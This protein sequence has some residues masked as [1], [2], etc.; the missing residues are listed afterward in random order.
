MVEALAVAI[1]R[2]AAGLVAAAEQ[3]RWEAASAATAGTGAAASAATAP[4]TWGDRAVQM[5][6]ELL[7]GALQQPLEGEGGS[8]VVGHAQVLGGLNEHVDVTWR[9]QLRRVSH[10]DRIS[11]ASPHACDAGR[12][13]VRV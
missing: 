10:L 4:F 5:A 8:L 9:L 13:M 11:D 12:A 3:R 7:L 6:D 1:T 2:L